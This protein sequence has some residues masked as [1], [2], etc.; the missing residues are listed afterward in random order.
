M[1]AVKKITEML[2]KYKYPLMV[3]VLGMILMLL[4]VGGEQLSS[5]SNDR[6]FEKL[7][8]DT[9]G[10]GKASVIISDKG[11]VVVCEGADS[12]GVRLDIVNSIKSYTGFG[13]D[14]VTI[15]KQK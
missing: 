1:D 2:K 11:V 9:R 3:L 14:K 6:K 8:C 13:A 12:A 7:L 4:P 15:L 5:G 10:V